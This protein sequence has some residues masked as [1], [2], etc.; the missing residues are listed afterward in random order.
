MNL[1]SPTRCRVVAAELDDTTYA[2][3]DLTVGL[4]SA[5]EKL[6]S[7]RTA[8][9]SDRVALRRGANTLRHQSEALA[10][11]AQS[12]SPEYVARA[13]FESGDVELTRLFVRAADQLEEHELF[14]NPEGGTAK[15]AA[16]LQ[17]MFE[18]DPEVAR[19]EAA[20]YLKLLRRVSTLAGQLSARATFSG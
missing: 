14:R 1:R 17:D 4:W 8:S 19:K 9:E 6:A 18:G 12:T 3:K 11:V 5:A 15:L 10:F 2:L 16:A 7:G 20:I 13:D